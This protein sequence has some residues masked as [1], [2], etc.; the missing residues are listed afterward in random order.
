[1]TKSESECQ[2]RYQPSPFYA[3]GHYITNVRDLWCTVV[4]AVEMEPICVT[5]SDTCMKEVPVPVTYLNMI[6]LPIVATVVV[7][8]A[9]IIINV[10]RSTTELHT[11]YYFLVAN[12]LATDIAV[13]INR[14]IVIVQY[15]TM[16]LY[17]LDLNS[18]N[19]YAVL[20]LVVFPTIPLT[21]LIIILLPVI[22]HDCYCISLLSQKHHDYK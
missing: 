9:A 5:S 6:Y 2:G 10:I 13:I 3:Y 12:L 18:E 7:T 1:M 15:L 19:A 14:V 16:I 21:Y 11:K 22:T 17:L 8:P 20:Q 4:K